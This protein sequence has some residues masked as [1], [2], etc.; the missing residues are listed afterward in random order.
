MAHHRRIISIANRSQQVAMLQMIGRSDAWKRE[1][2]ITVASRDRHRTLFPILPN[3]KFIRGSMNRLLHSASPVSSNGKTRRARNALKLSA[4]F[5]ADSIADHP[6][7]TESTLTKLAKID[8]YVLSGD[9]HSA[10]K[11]L[12][13][14]IAGSDTL[15]LN[16]LK[17]IK[18]VVRMHLK[19]ED[20]KSA[21]E[22]LTLCREKINNHIK[23]YDTYEVTIKLVV[24]AFARQGR[25][26]DVVQCTTLP[27]HF[28]LGC[29][30]WQVTVMQTRIL[31]FFWSIR[32]CYAPSRFIHLPVQ[33]P[34]FQ[35]RGWFR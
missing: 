6:K 24:L 5:Q 20:T 26:T 12:R 1:L 33:C 17:L 31:S 4:V 28:D 29:L 13:L 7:A 3:H 15:E 30:A 19:S 8:A 25:T 23:G 21:G 34:L 2:P 11:W 32:Y 22:L 35:T 14:L 18:K 16:V 9:R 27:S 10:Q